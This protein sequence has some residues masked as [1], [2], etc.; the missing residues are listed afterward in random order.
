VSNY[1]LAQINIARLQAPLD[2]PQL[3][4]FVANLDRIN[5]LAESAPGFIWRLKTEDG[6]ATALRPLDESTI[7]NLSVWTDVTALNQFV[8]RTAHVEIMRRRKEWFERM[9]EAYVALWWI[10]KEHLPSVAEALDRLEHLRQHGPS[11]HAFNFRQPFPAPDEADAADS[12]SL[13]VDCPT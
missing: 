5:A 9:A 12:T 3:T 7:V 1:H 6:N 11:P 10:R 13:L 2:S 8:Y 4:D